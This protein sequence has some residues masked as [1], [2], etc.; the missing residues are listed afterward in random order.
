MK[1]IFGAKKDKGPPPSI[2]DATERVSVFSLPIRFCC[3]PAPVAPFSIVA[4]TA[5]VHGQWAS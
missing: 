3:N 1:K 4:V 5:L 2:Q